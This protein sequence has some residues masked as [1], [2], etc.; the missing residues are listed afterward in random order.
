MKLTHWKLLFAV[1]L[2][3]TAAGALDLTVDQPVPCNVF[4]TGSEVRLPVTISDK[5]PLKGTLRIEVRDY[6]GKKLLE[7]EEKLSGT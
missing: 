7:R 4:E 2:A 6:T 3:A 1:L 5:K